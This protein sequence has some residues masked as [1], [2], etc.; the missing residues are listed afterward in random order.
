MAFHLL[1]GEPQA[2]CSAD[3]CTSRG[4]SAS[5]TRHQIP[6]EQGLTASL[7]GWRPAVPCRPGIYGLPNPFRSHCHAGDPACTR[8]GGVKPAAKPSVVAT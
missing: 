3:A 6:M 5:I 7:L 8:R 2:T 1:K 4:S